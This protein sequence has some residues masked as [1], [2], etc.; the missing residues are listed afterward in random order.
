MRAERKRDRQRK[1]D[2]ER[3]RER[4][5]VLTVDRPEFESWLCCFIVV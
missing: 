4:G 3:E 1:R 5:K 2:R